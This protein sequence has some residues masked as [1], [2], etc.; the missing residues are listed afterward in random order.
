MS[1]DVDGPAPIIKKK[2]VVAGDGHHGGAWKVAYADFVTA[3]MAFF[4]LMWLLNATTERQRKGIADYFAPTIP[5][6]PVSGGGNGLFQGESMQATD[7]LAKDGVG[8]G[9]GE[10]EIEDGDASKTGGAPVTEQGQELS[11]ITEKLFGRTG[12]SE[13]EDELLKHIVTKVTD[14][15]LVIDIFAK[16]GRPLFGVGS[17]EPTPIM[18]DILDMIASVVVH[19][20]NQMVVTGHT[21]GLP[22]ATPDY[23]N[24]RLS[25][26]RADE[27][28][29]ALAGAGVSLGR[30]DRISGEADRNLAIPDNPGDPRN[31]RIT[32]TL[33]RSDR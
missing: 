16:E 6:A 8:G 18:R 2:K 31:R 13:A 30:F 23:D 1:N 3:M 14:E 26:D 33:L 25:S 15:G 4:L 29:R 28:R 10:A 12:E 17:A 7:D 19:V 5:L 32:L 20:E 9:D 21:D 24:W 27:V 22:F 11:D